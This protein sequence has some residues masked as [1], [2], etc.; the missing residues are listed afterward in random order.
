VQEKLRSRTAASKKVRKSPQ[1]HIDWLE[2]RITHIDDDLERNL[3]ASSVWRVKEDLLHGIPGIG[4]VTTWTLLLKCPELG[5]LDRRRKS[6]AGGRGPAGQGQRQA[7][8]ASI[9]ANVP[10]GAGARMCARCY[11]W[12]H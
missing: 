6:G 7:S 4:P 2:K 8:A 9:V 3:Q 11:T 1:K 5:Q 12:R 10:S